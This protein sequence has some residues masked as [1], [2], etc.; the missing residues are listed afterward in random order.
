M[1]NLDKVLYPGSRFTKARVIE[2]YSRV[3]PFLLPHLKNRPV[4]LLRFPDGVFGESFY[5]KNAPGFV[6]GWIRT[7]P[8]PR[9]EGGVI[10]YILVNDL[11]TLVWLA[12]LAAL[13]LH[14]FLHRTPRIDRP[15]HVVFDLDPGEGS[16][17]LTCIEVALLVRE[18]LGRLK[19]E[20]FPKV[21]GSKG[22][23][24][25]VPLNTAVSYDTT[26]AFA[27]TVANLLARQHPGLVVSEMA[28]VLRAGKVFIDWS[29]NNQ[30]KTTVGVYS[31]RAKRE[32]PFVS[33]PVT[34]DEL[35]AA[36]EA[37]DP[38]RLFFEPDA[39]LDRLE[40]TGDLFAPVLKLKQKLPREFEDALATAA[41]ARSPKLERYAARRD[42]R[43]TIEPGPTV[44]RRSAQGSRRRFV[45]QKHAASHLH[46][47]FRLEMHDV[48]K[49]WAV[50]KEIPLKRG[51]K[52]S[53]FA[54]EDHPVEYLDFEGT[55]PRGQYGGGT[56]MVWD[57]GTYEPVEGNYYRGDLRVFLSGSKLNG[58][59]TLKKLKSGAG[60]KETWL[61]IKTGEDA[62]PIPSSR[63]ERS[64]L[65]GRTL[66]QIS[67]QPGAVWQ[68]N[69]NN[70][71]ALT[72]GARKQHPIHAEVRTPKA[73]AAKT[74][75]RS[76]PPAAVP[77]FVQPMRASPAEHLPAGDEWLY[78]VKWDGYRALA[79]KSGESVQLLS[80]KNKNLAGEFPAVVEAVRTVQAETALLD[81]EIVAVNPQ[82]QP[83]FQALQNRGALRPGWR[84]VY[85][86]FDLLSLEGEDLKLLPLEERKRKLEEL[87]RGSDVRH[88]A[89]LPGAP[90]DIVK[91]VSRAGLEGIIAKRKDSIYAGRKTRSP[92]WQ[93]LKITLSQEFVLG[94]YNP[95]GESFSSVLAGYYSGERFMFAGKVRQGFNPGLRARLLRVLRPLET[96]RCPFANLP[97]SR[98]GH[99]GEG[100][101]LEDMRKLRWLQP[102]LVAQVGFTEWT[103][104]GLLRHATFLGLRQ[105]KNPG[106][107]VR[108]T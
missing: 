5:E 78:E 62:R 84:V 80:L 11:P 13:E 55:I 68:S 71:A 2:Y 86:A 85:Y 25:Y 16:N 50:P 101:T 100:I 88:S 107:V 79:A 105:D 103:Q 59:W 27:R 45:V 82:G 73:R 57:T 60:E 20:S 104:Y 29:Q 99:F 41:P 26:Q 42:F 63:A 33:M 70:S 48:L 74:N 83:S 36:S 76:R 75:A 10:R 23:Q 34:W 56:V 93:K 44:R 98:T 15:T 94:G 4:T 38:E 66:D 96:T 8:V 65:S 61:L 53:A 18:L 69:R 22:L 51:D 67:N 64:A 7:F 108:E 35:R 1:S 89:A 24:L 58:E 106:E 102:K 30:S 72:S 17:L 28:K 47:D 49:S 97:S 21:S 81:G 9:S 12:N 91:A 6:P 95:D 54:T 14:P 87:I 31:L 32:R 3:S 43:K 39:A 92:A 37:G 52:R 46:Y 77:E 19:L 90:E 40:N